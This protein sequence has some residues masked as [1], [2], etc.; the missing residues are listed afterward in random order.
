MSSEGLAF[1]MA[2]EQL[3]GEQIRET[4]LLGNDPCARAAF[5][6]AQHMRKA[7]LDY[8]KTYKKLIGGPS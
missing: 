3:A 8:R 5:D 7:I 4:N 6:S 2:A 1:I